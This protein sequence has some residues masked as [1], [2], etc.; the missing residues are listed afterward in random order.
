VHSALEIAPADAQPP[1]PASTARAATR[2][3]ACASRSA[4][5]PR[6]RRGFDRRGTGGPRHSIGGRETAGVRMSV[7]SIVLD[8]NC[9]S[10][11]SIQ[12]TAPRSRH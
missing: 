5:R 7:S 11:A 4:R 8:H 9:R 3:S 2:G 6:A 12:I 10:V 1:R